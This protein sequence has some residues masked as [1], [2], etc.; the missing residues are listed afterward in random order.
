MAPMR[1]DSWIPVAGDVREATHEGL[2]ALI[3]ELDAARMVL[4]RLEIDDPARFVRVAALTAR[5]A[6]Y[7]SRY[8]EGLEL[9]RRAAGVATDSPDPDRALANLALGWLANTTRHHDEAA[10]AAAGAAGG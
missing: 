7:D 8:R 3:R 1:T 10:D 4:D 5:A 6:H 9:A 2:W